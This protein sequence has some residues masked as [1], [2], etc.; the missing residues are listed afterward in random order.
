[1]LCKVIIDGDADAAS[2]HRSLMK[3]IRAVATASANSTPSAT[4]HLASNSTA[5]SYELIDTVIDNTVAGGW[6][7]LT[8]ST[9]LVADSASSAI[10]TPELL[11]LYTTTG[12]S[13]RPYSFIHFY[14]G[15]YGANWIDT[16]YS[17]SIG[18]VWGTGTLAQ[19]EWDY[20]YDNTGDENWNRWFNVSSQNGKKNTGE[21]CFLPAQSVGTGNTTPT[22]A[23]FLKSYDD[24]ATYNRIYYIAANST[25][26]TIAACGQDGTTEHTLSTEGADYYQSG[27]FF[28]WGERTNTAWEDNYNDNPYWV[29][30]WQLTNNEQTAY[31]DGG[32]W[33]RMR[34]KDVN[35]TVTGPF[36]HFDFCTAQHGSYK[37]NPLNGAFNATAT[38]Y[39]Q[40][41]SDYYRRDTYY[42]GNVTSVTQGLWIPATTEAQLLNDIFGTTVNNYAMYHSDYSLCSPLMTGAYSS[43]YLVAGGLM[44]S[45]EADSSTGAQIP[46]AIPIRIESEGGTNAGGYMK[47]IFNSCQVRDYTYLDSIRIK[48]AV[49]TFNGSKYICLNRGTYRTNSNIEQDLFWI[50]V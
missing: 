24:Y 39:H 34:R 2:Q 14:G 3:A 28:H 48:E 8:T 33:T 36:S 30:I 20:N 31:K 38:S 1:M 32:Y 16:T 42:P 46:P 6:T 35:G 18:I 40:Y 44:Y 10:T 27:G 37:R 19:A 50:H 22:T 7:E 47:N 29:A 41:E 23:G 9:T 26:I 45:P 25:A 12:K 11:T 43:A 21:V 49:Y 5:D 13:G 15:A 17:N 4:G